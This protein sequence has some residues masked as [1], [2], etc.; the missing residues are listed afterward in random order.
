MIIKNILVALPRTYF[1]NTFSIMKKHLSILCYL[2]ACSLTLFA[3]N[4]DKVING[5]K[6]IDLGLPSGLLWAETNVGA[7]DAIEAGEYY[8]WGEIQPKH[9]YSWRTYAFKKTNPYGSD[10]LKAQ[11]DV[12]T[13]KWGPGCRI[14]TDAEFRE[15]CKFCKWKWQTS[16]TV[17]YVVTGPNG[18]SIFLPAAGHRDNDNDH[19]R[20][21]PINFG[22]N[23]SYWTS[24]RYT[25]PDYANNAHCFD[26]GDASLR[27]DHTFRY[28]GFSIRPVA[29]K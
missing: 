27:P 21:T 13:V 29:E 3:A 16:G 4:P 24:T 9:D 23:G 1:T 25:A 10:V 15:L 18:K 6:F 17:G 7:S 11:D 20:Q 5:H 14:P 19:E 12:A 8:A 22:F 28:L 2:F 26:F